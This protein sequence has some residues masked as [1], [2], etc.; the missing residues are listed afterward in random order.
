[1]LDAT[2]E[3]PQSSFHVLAAGG[4]GAALQ[5]FAGDVLGVRYL[6][7]AQTRHVFLAAVF[8]EL[9]GAGGLSHEH[10]QDAGGHGVQGAAVAYPFFVEDAPDL[11]ADVHAGPAL[12]LVNDEDSVRH[13]KTPPFLAAQPSEA[14]ALRKGGVAR[15]DKPNRV[16]FGVPSGRTPTRSSPGACR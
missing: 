9:H 13:R 4:D 8:R 16:R 10:R 12:G 5:R 7:Q 6:A 14:G 2:Q 15:P 3:A 11:G 1:M